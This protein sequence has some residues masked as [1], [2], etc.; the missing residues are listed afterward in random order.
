VNTS[1]AKQEVDKIY[2]ELMNEPITSPNLYVGELGILIFLLEYQSFYKIKEEDLSDRV[3]HAIQNSLNQEQGASICS[4]LSGLAWFLQYCVNRDLIEPS[5]IENVQKEIDEVISS[6]ALEYYRESNH[7]FMHGG[8][9]ITFSLIYRLEAGA[10][11]S[12]L[13]LNLFN[14]SEE[15]SRTDGNGIYWP[16]MDDTLGK[17]KNKE[18]VS[19]GLA[20]GLA[21]KIA[22][23]AKIVKNHPHNKDVYDLLMCTIH[24]VK[25]KRLTDEESIFPSC[26]IDKKPDEHS[27]LAWCHGDLAVA[28]SLCCAG[29]ALKDKEVMNLGTDIARHS[30][31]RSFSSSGVVD[32]SICHG[33]AGLAMLYLKIFEISGDHSFKQEGISWLDK[34]INFNEK[35]DNLEGYYFQMPDGRVPVEG[36]LNGTAG[37]GLM[38][39]S[40]LNQEKMSWSECLLL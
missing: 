17:Y 19:F 4:G 30:I 27:R 31:S 35:Y 9:G 23:M 33:S 10:D 32:T 15:N 18:I 5:E 7:D 21:S 34:T 38:Y 40:Y 24:F 6:Q 39:L 2:A 14:A 1:Q 16:E 37:V 3:F 11:V 36:L 26:L 28:Y 22:L 29:D 25:Q 20:H 12:S 8:D 13:I